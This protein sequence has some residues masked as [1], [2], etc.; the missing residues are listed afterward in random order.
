MLIPKKRY[1]IEERDDQDYLVTKYSVY[2][3][4]ECG[5]IENKIF[6]VYETEEECQKDIDNF[7][8]FK[9]VKVS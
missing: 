2:D 4:D 6:G 8:S 7:N 5:F 3:T 1:V 9:I